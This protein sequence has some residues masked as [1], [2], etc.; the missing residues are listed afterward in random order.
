MKV[1]FLHFAGEEMVLRGAES[2]DSVKLNIVPSL[3][4]SGLLKVH[5]KNL[6]K[7]FLLNC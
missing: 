4:T 6:V 5:D 3:P 2:G 7:A 1:F